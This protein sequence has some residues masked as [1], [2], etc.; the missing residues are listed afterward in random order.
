MPGQL[1]GQAPNH[2][3]RRRPRVVAAA[4]A[5]LAA[6]TGL[7]L[8]LGHAAD[9]A[10]AGL[11][12]TRPNVVVL[13][14]DDQETASMRVM[15]TVN[16][17]M[18][19]KGTTMKRFYAS[20]PLCCPSRATLLTGQYAH[21]HGVL[22]NQAPE[23]GYGVFNE[24]H[25]DNNLALWMQGAGYST[26]YIGKFLN[27]YAEPDEYGTVPSDV[28]RGWDDWRVLA[29][30]KAE[31]FGYRLNQNGVVTGRG[32]RKRDYSTDVFTD[33][34]RKFIRR[35]APGIDPFFLMLGYAAPHGGGGGSPGRSC[36][37]AA[38]PAPRHLSTL[39][40]EKKKF[41][42]SSF[43]EDDVSDKPSPIAERDPLTPGQVRDTLR[44]RRCAWESLLAVDESVGEL[45]EQ[46]KRS[47]ERRNTYIFFLSDNG[48]MRGEHRLRNTKR[49]L[50]EPSARVP[51]IARGPGI[52]R[53]GKSS[54]V[55]TNADLVSTISE[56]T[57]VAPGLPQDGE[58][59]MPTLRNPR[60]E[61]GRA[62]LLEAYA[63]DEMIG[64]R[65]HRYLYTEWDT[66]R[67]QPEIELYDTYADPY[68]LN[69]LAQN[70]GYAPVVADL[71]QQLDALIGC[72]GSACYQH[73][74]GQLDF[75]TGGAGPRGCA[76]PPITAR[77]F[78]S[79]AGR[80]RTVDFRVEGDFAGT[81]AEPPFEIVVPDKL[82][83][84]ALPK[85]AEVVAEANLVDGRRLGL[86]AKIKICK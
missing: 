28:P 5:L 77:V 31:Y 37:R 43:N 6:A 34:A 74:T 21:N 58:S 62:A 52:E 26:A 75:N 2:P 51:F 25:G 85:A 53:G 20:F 79:S 8:A 84:N 56:L 78:S 1:P 32:Q 3:L 59:L 81:D 71:A 54:D 50:Y 7:A 65:T 17:E 83:R 30:S 80:L 82:L 9:P 36:N 18:K 12:Q 60:L 13:F 63:G 41:L 44:K 40:D 27:E 55:V 15:K 33:K 16:K 86:P 47:G 35:N 14:T 72:A 19:R 46:L 11:E 61:R 66:D 4:A 49:Y 24:L 38:E 70:P 39:K 67:Q 48:Y 29:P 22:S 64:V 76:L 10:A 23:G 73:P 45:L 69:N 57:G 68:E 42:P